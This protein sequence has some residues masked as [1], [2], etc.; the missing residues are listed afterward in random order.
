MKEP[1]RLEYEGKPEV[2][3]S[4][5]SGNTEANSSSDHSIFVPE[6]GLYRSK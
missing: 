2:I 4:F 6:G 3:K 1:G 5:D